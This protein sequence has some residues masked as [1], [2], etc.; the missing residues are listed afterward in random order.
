MLWQDSGCGAQCSMSLQ[1]AEQLAVDAGFTFKGDDSTR[2]D[3]QTMFEHFDVNSLSSF[4][5]LFS[6]HQLRPG[7]LPVGTATGGKAKR[8]KATC[9]PAD[10]GGSSSSSASSSGWQVQQEGESVYIGGVKNGKREGSGILLSR[11]RSS[12]QLH[13]GQFAEGSCNGLGVVTS[14]GGERLEGNFL[15]GMPWGPA[16]Y[17]F[18]PP[19]QPEQAAA[20]PASHR[21]RLQYVGM[22]NGR[23]LGMGRTAWTDG[24]Q[25]FGQFDGLTC[26]QGLEEAEVSGVLAVADD[27]SSKARALEAAIQ[28]ALRQDPLIAQ[29]A[30]SLFESVPA[31]RTTGITQLDMFD[32]PLKALHRD[33][34]AQS[35]LAPDPLVDEVATRLLDRLEDCRRSFETAIVLGGA[36]AKVA[37]RLAGGRSGIQQVIHV[38]TSMA[39]LERA[40][41]HVEASSSG[42]QQPHTRYVHWQADS[43]IL[44]LEPGCADLVVSCL[45]LHWVND[46]PE[47]RIACTVAQQ[48][49]EGGVSP[50]VSPLAQVRDAGNLLMRAGLAIPAVD[51]DDI[52]VH[53][54]DVVQL[55][56]HLRS[57]G[58]SSGLTK[59]RQQL[60]RDVALA[61]AAAYAGL[62]AEEDG[63]IPATYEVIYMTGWAPHP[64]QQQPAKRGSAT[65]SFEALE[66]E[67]GPEGEDG[68]GSGGGAAGAS[69]D[70]TSSKGEATST[71]SKGV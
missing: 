59:R 8:G 16:V 44:P 48:D 66:K 27:N 50:R 52:Q 3:L 25:E 24:S 30:Q 17:I 34:A 32:G 26:C 47:L 35:P 22:M 40:R 70:G 14:S 63:S 1:D 6:T 39:M 57:M 10:Y 42:R 23:P 29:Q 43:E 37:E 51:V 2:A 45:G 19:Q 67:L 55:V 9:L 46:V 61:A 54:A 65:V 60:P 58:E 15:D 69:S 49:R 12:W 28:E 56:Q 53:Y 20:G 68:S 71:D 13:I 36:G 4:R 11:G 21:S 7:P 5:R 38:D 64:G 33:R 31:A 62:F 41:S 18:A